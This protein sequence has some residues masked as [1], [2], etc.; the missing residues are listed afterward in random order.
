MELVERARMGDLEAFAE[1]T[2][3]YQGM[4]L[5]YAFALLH[6]AE[7]AQD[8]VQE[9]FVAAYF[10]LDQL[11]EP[12]AFP[13][14]LRTVV[15]TQ[16][17]RIAR[18][19]RLDEVPL[20]E[21]VALEAERDR[22]DQQLERREARAHVLAAVAT[23]APAHREVLVL[24]YVEQYSHAEIA[25]FLDLPTTT[26]NMRLHAARKALRDRI[27][28]LVREA[29][30]AGALPHDFPE[31]VARIIAAWRQVPEPRTGRHA[32]DPGVAAGWSTP[33][34]LGRAGPRR[35]GWTAATADADGCPC[36]RQDWPCPRCGALEG[37]D[38]T[39]PFV[40]AGP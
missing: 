27:L 23:L 20:D 3:R 33:P 25:A 10:A 38:P 16:C 1:L 2:R 14:W 13:G 24:H 18:Q 17:G 39:P 26:V 11:R 6:D 8:A 35:I 21:A 28:G 31:R 29:L 5:G 19:R 4:A 9:A 30:R 12:P 7:L 15:R 34:P 37:I 36:R 32:F 22:P 40:F